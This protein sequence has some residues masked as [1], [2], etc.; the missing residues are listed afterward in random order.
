MSENNKFL[1]NKSIEIG[2]KREKIVIRFLEPHVDHIEENDDFRWDILI[3]KGNKEITIEVKFNSMF[4]KTGNFAV[5]FECRGKPSGINTT[6]S[7]YWV[8]VDSNDKIYCI[9]TEKLRELCK[10]SKIKPAFCEDGVNNN[11]L[12]KESLFKPHQIELLSILD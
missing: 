10:V 1:F 7:N 8:F 11:Y 2:K 9:K 6:K 3:K 12:V 5:E 4:L